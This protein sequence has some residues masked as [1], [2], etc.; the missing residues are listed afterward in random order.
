MLH[1]S[2]FVYCPWFDD[3]A[4]L[5]CPR[6]V[7]EVQVYPDAAEMTWDLDVGACWVLMAYQSPGLHAIAEYGTGL[8]FVKSA[9]I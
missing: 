8:V 5:H 9:C 2:Q 3:E 6:E 7:R 1:L 4:T